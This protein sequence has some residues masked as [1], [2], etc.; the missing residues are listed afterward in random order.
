MTHLRIVESDHF[1][2]DSVV[3]ICSNYH[4][5]EF[6]IIYQKDGRIQNCIL[7]KVYYRYAY[8]RTYNLAKSYNGFLAI[9]YTIPPIQEYMS[10]FSRQVIGLYDTIDH[11]DDDVSKGYKER[12]IIAGH[13]LD[14][15]T[16]TS[17]DFNGTRGSDTLGLVVIDP[18]STMFC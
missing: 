15:V 11:P 8:Y 6:N 5:F 3:V 10:N 12:Y 14:T 16:T 4:N 13:V 1:E 17:F 7:T 18:K 2:I 9:P